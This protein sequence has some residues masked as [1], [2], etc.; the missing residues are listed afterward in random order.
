PAGGRA[1]SSPSAAAT[2]VPGNRSAAGGRASPG[3]SSE[4]PAARASNMGCRCPSR[5]RSRADCSDEL[6]RDGG[7]RDDGAMQD[8][9]VPPLIAAAGLRRLS[10]RPQL[11]VVDCRFELTDPAFGR[12]AYAAGHLPGAV[13]VSVENDLAAPR[14]PDTGRHPL[15]TPEAFA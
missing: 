6:C 13:F 1:D 11:L 9:P 15:P 5:R 3:A 2:C 7:R 14:G 8:T 4:V 10:G 12:R